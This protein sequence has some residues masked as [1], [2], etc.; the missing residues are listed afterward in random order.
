[1]SDESTQRVLSLVD[2]LQALHAQKYPPVRDISSYGLYEL[3]RSALPDV[4]GVR[5]TPADSVWLTVDFVELP[6]R[7]A[8]PEHLAWLLGPADELNAHSPPCLSFPTT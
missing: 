5:L 6:T 2:F 8:F 3:E 1:M 7:P 4:S